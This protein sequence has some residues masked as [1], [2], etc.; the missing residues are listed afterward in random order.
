VNSKRTQ[1][2]IWEIASEYKIDPEEARRSLAVGGLYRQSVDALVPDTDARRIFAKP[3]RNPPSRE[4]PARD[5]DQH[6]D[7]LSEAAKMFEVDE[8]SLKPRRDAA[9]QP[10]QGPARASTRPKRELTDWDREVIP[11]DEAIEW[12]DNGVYDAR[13]AAKARRGGLSPSDMKIKL[14]GVSVGQ[15]LINGESMASVQ[16]RLRE[17]DAERG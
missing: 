2:R 13:V 7:A 11:S 9:T 14:D 10:K 3:G 6:S 5:R 4:R 12:R 1:V 8:R 16:S 17:R 15:R